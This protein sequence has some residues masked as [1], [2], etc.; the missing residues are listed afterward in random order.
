MWARV[1]MVSCV[2]PASSPE[3]KQ[4]PYMGKFSVSGLVREE[5]RARSA[6]QGQGRH[7]AGSP[8]SAGSPGRWYRRALQE[9]NPED[10]DG[11]LG[12]EEE[13]EDESHYG[14]PARD[15][16]R[17][18]AGI[19]DPQGRLGF[20]RECL[21]GEPSFPFRVSAVKRN[22]NFKKQPSLRRASAAVQQEEEA[23]GRAR[24]THP[25][26]PDGEAGVAAAAEAE[27]AAAGGGQAAAPA[28][29]P[30]P[31]R[32]SPPRT[33]PQPLQAQ[34]WPQGCHRGEQSIAYPSCTAVE[35]VAYPLVGRRLTAS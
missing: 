14:T 28:G 8:G 9:Y 19:D 32:G 7:G 15:V 1:L 30:G 23:A 4:C 25:G 34:Q 5:R 11:G 10:D 13:D 20:H 26:R 33:Q 24:C 29:R 3:P 6:G 18:P 12:E 21:L 2:P 17:R 27:P 22:N 31:H 35:R 16:R